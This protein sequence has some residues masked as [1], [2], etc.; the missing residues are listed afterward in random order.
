M[1]QAAKREWNRKEK[2]IWVQGAYLLDGQE[3]TCCKK[4]HPILITGSYFKLTLH[5]SLQPI[6]AT[7]IFSSLLTEKMFL[8]ETLFII[9]RGNESIK[10]DFPS[11]RLPK[12]K[13]VTIFL[14]IIFFLFW[15]QRKR[16]SYLRII[17]C[18]Y[19]HSSAQDLYFPFLSFPVRS[20]HAPLMAFVMACRVPKF[21]PCF[22][23]VPFREHAIA[24]QLT[25]YCLVF[26]QYT[27]IWLFSWTYG[28]NS[29]QNDFLLAKFNC[30][31]PI[32][33]LISF[34]CHL[35]HLMDPTF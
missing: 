33:S 20:T 4:T 35:A 17:P 6:T 14:L 23:L 7:F 1:N 29:C 12:E 2:I 11:C 15:F 9:H 13:Y 34:L 31:F 18:W 3:F 22:L 28:P 30:L 10:W 25:T 19:I 21:L 5:K 24:F 27:W 16:Y 8:T 32:L 26:P